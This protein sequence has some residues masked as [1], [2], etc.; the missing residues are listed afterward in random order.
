MKPGLRSWRTACVEAARRGETLE[1]PHPS[2]TSLTVIG[3]K[4][5]LAATAGKHS[6]ALSRGSAGPQPH[7]MFVMLVESDI[8]QGVHGI[9]P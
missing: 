6:K 2:S 8:R 3:R 5:F 7:S 1:T 4:I 9:L